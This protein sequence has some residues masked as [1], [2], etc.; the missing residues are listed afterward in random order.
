M[1]S[2][3]SDLATQAISYADGIADAIVAQAN[4]AQSEIAAEQQKIREEQSKKAA[5]SDASLPWETTEESKVILSEGLMHKILELSLVEENFSVAP[6]GIEKVQFNLSS[7]VPVAMRMLSIDSNLAKIHAKLVPVMNEEQFWRNYHFRIVFLR[8]FVGVESEEI[9]LDVEERDVIFPAD[10]ELVASAKKLSKPVNPTPSKPT[11]DAQAPDTPNVLDFASFLLSTP[12]ALG[13][14][15]APTT[16]TAAISNSEQGTNAVAQSPKAVEPI[17]ARTPMTPLS[18]M[19]ALSPPSPPSISTNTPSAAV[20]ERRKSVQEL[21]QEEEEIKKKAEAEKRERAER[22]LA[23][24]VEA[25]LN[26]DDN[27]NLDDMDLDDLGD[28]DDLNLDDLDLDGEEFDDLGD[29][30]LDDV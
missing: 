4:A 27:I 22:A 2:W 14:P 15:S 12:S 19:T 17:A 20:Q 5:L 26:T 28:L 30:D 8:T 23:A 25:E 29:L 21:K 10:P 24:A 16:T 11:N 3:F 1:S 18:P 9:F 7:F 6:P 13:I